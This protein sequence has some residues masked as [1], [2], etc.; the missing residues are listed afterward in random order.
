MKKMKGLVVFA[1][2]LSACLL[3]SISG[4]AQVSTAGDN[5]GLT[6]A[7][8]ALIGTN[9]PTISMS[10]QPLASAGAKLASVSNSNLFIKVSSLVPTGTV[11]KITVRLLTG[12][13]PAGTQLTIQPVA[14]TT[15]NSGGALGTVSLT[16]VAISSVDQNLITSIGSCYTGTASS[17]GYNMIFNWSIV[18]PTTT[19]GQIVSKSSNPVIV[20]TV[21]APE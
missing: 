13:I 14:S 2:L 15:A 18:N 8:L 5:I 21:T 19:Y 3:F 20:F 17:D 9:A 12:T 10:F 4:Q 6:V 11:R 7:S 1:I 16:P